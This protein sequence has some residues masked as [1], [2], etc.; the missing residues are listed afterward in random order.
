MTALQDADQEVLPE[1]R[2]PVARSS[3]QRGLPFFCKRTLDVLVAAGVGVA[4]SPVAAAVAVAIKVDSPGPVIYRGTRVGQRGELFTMFKFR[5]MRADA[6]DAMHIAYVE[7]LMRDKDSSNNG[8][9][10]D[11][12]KLEDDPRI[13]RVGRWIRRLSIDELPQ[14]VNV[15]RGEMSLVGPRPEVPAV[16]SVYQPQ[17]F[18]RFAVLPGMTGLWQV[19]GRGKLSPADMI[20][21]DVDYADNWTLGTDLAILLRTPA[22]VLKKTGAE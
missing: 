8:D 22:V 7:R 9:Q 1:P 2:L 20:R 18:R 6:D 11:M 17:Q 12:F 13:T 16:L 21:L 14:L 10:A 4:L 5:S 3:R 19:N 15:V